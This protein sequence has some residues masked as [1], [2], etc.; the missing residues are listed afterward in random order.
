MTEFETGIF[1]AGIW[2]STVADGEVEF[3]SSHYD[4]AVIKRVWRDDQGR[5]CTRFLAEVSRCPGDTDETLLKRAEA[6]AQGLRD[7]G[8]ADEGR[9]WT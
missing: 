8:F 2:P 7:A 6:M 3:D 5:R 1:A 9:L 4:R